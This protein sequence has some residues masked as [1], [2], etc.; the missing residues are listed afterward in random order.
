MK[1][2][3]KLALAQCIIFIVLSISGHASMLISGKVMDYLTRKPIQGA[4]ITANNEVVQTDSNGMFVIRN[5]T[6][7]IGIRACG[8]GRGE[9]V[10]PFPAG[11]KPLKVYLQPF[12]PKPLYLPLY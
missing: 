5:A 2:I 9:R 6:K 11:K 8:Y 1:R 7:K 10:I 12:P 4:I 3:L